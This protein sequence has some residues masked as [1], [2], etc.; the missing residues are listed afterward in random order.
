ME[1]LRVFKPL[2]EWGRICLFPPPP[3]LYTGCPSAYGLGSLLLPQVAAPCLHTG[4]SPLDEPEAAFVICYSSKAR[5]R[6]STGKA[7]LQVAPL[8][9]PPFPVC[10]PLH[11]TVS[12]RGVSTNI[13]PCTKE[14]VK[15]FPFFARLA[16]IS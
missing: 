4:K 14:N 15:S 11:C 16:W 5:L 12:W 13:S 8:P 1:T 10:F 2:T 3:C 7:E 9:F 6:P